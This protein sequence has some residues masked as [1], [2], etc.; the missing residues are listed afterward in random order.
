MDVAA[1]PP[2][3]PLP[4]PIV[5]MQD[6]DMLIDV[7]ERIKQAQAEAGAAADSSARPEKFQHVARVGVSEYPINDDMLESALEWEDAEV[8][9]SLGGDDTGEWDIPETT[10]DWKSLIQ[11]DCVWFDRVP[12][13][14][15]KADAFEFQRLIRMD[16]IEVMP[17]M[18]DPADTCKELSSTFVRTWRPKGSMP[19]T[20][21]ASSKLGST[22]LRRLHL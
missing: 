15:E 10:E 8:Y 22:H 13:L 17:D 11:E 12:E 14:D 4:P 16:V 1:T 6:S 7:A 21:S 20:W 9:L 3:T 2:V 18:D 5:E 19:Q